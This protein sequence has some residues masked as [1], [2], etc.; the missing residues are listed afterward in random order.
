MGDSIVSVVAILLI[1]M[2][3]I[4]LVTDTIEVSGIY[5]HSYFSG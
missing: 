1:T 5:S 3:L 4:F 2:L